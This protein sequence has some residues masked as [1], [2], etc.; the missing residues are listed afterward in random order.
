MIAG[1]VLAAG[2]GSRMGTP[3][4]VVELAGCT[5]LERAV[6]TL[7]CGGC[8]EVLAV[9]PDALPRRPRAGDARLVTNPGWRSG[10]G[11][12]LRAG[13]GAAAATGAQAAVVLLV[14]TPLVG[15][16]AVLRLSRAWRG[17]AAVAVATYGGR[18]GHPVLLG[19]AHWAEAAELARGDVGARAFLVAR[20]ELVLEVPCD[21]TGDPVDV[22]TPEELARVSAALARADPAGPC[23]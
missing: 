16:G 6:R 3:K 12:S 20:P 15:P 9:V 18:R 4:A 11:S 21:G 7:S 13:L 10:M 1:V 5:L 8:A 17:G 19:R 22:D 23:T 2:A 14:D